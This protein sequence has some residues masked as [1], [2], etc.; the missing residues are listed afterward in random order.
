MNQWQDICDGGK[1]L[2]DAALFTLAEADTWFTW[3]RENVPWRQEAVHGRPLP[4][5]NAW[6]SDAGLRYSYSGVSHLGAGW[7][8]ELLDIKDRVEA[9]A[10]VLF[11]SLLLNRYRDGRDSIG[12]H[13]DAEPELGRDP[14]VA[15]LSFG[16]ERAFVLK[17][18]RTRETI[19]YR[20]GHGSLLVMGGASQHH[21]LHAVPKTE[22]AVGE[23]ISLT[24]RRIVEA[25]NGQGVAQPAP[26]TTDQDCDGDVLK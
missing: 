12:F 20:L 16:S 11:N 19:T 26:A 1:L 14:V 3:L 10:G 8:P 4:R 18:K 22:S 25:G 13:T 9:A 5:L 21:W 17:H 6:F 2:Y 7:P 24:F 23:R 15:T